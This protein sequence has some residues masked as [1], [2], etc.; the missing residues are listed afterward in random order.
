LELAKRDLHNRQDVYA[1]DALAWALVKN[2]QPQ[3][4]EKA[5]TEALKLGTRDAML[6][7]HAGVIQQ[8]LGEAAKARDYL[9]RALAVNPHFSLTQA[10]DARQRLAAL[11]G[12]KP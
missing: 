12:A 3:E 9:G 1:H 8:Q 2:G 10:E 4:A 5:M 7:Y 11:G 6:F